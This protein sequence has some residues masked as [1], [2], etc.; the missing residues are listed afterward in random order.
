[1]WKEFKNFIMTGNVIDFAVGVILAG[2]VGAV[3]NGFVNDIVM[4]VVGFLTGGVDFSDMKMVL[5][6]AQLGPDGKEAVPE[7]AIFYGRWITSIISLITIG[8]VLFIIVKAYNKMRTPA[9][10]P[11]PAGPSDN[12]LLAEIRDLLKK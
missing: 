1:M 7:V 11:P 12:E 4:P 8:F 3:V 2:A 10:A 5:A 6:A 9:A